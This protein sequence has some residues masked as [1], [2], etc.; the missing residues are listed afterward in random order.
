MYDN[1][2]KHGTLTF[3]DEVYPGGPYGREGAERVEEEYMISIISG[4]LGTPFFN[5]GGYI[6]A[7]KSLVDIFRNF[8]AGFIF[9]TSLPLTVLSGATTSIQVLRSEEGQTLRARHKGNVDYHRKTLLSSSLTEEHTLSHIIPDHVGNPV[10]TTD[11]SNC[12]IEKHIYSIASTI[13]IILH[14][15]ILIIIS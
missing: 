10:L 3:V 13:T 12:L 9:T 8:G 2:Y 1:S 5:V 14:T 15:S 6:A 11:L 4:N 7:S